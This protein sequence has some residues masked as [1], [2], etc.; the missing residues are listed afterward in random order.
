MNI[1]SEAWSRPI[2]G[3][4]IF[5]WEQKL[6]FTKLA[7]KEWVKQTVKY[8]SSDRI[9]VLKFLQ[10]IQL[11]M[12]EMGLTPSKLEKEQKAQFNAF[13]AFTKEEEY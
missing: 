13:R 5:V 6:K 1:V 8:P 9:E 10:D 7:L 11:E 2:T 12:D 4:P 3:S